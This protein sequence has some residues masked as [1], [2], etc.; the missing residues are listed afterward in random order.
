[1]RARPTACVRVTMAVHRVWN[2]DIAVNVA[3]VSLCYGYLTCLRHTST[4]MFVWILSDREG[5]SRYGDKA[6]SS[7]NDK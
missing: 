2:T 6:N 3:S 5:H 1:M 4:D 7:I